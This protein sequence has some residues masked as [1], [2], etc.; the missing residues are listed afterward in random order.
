MKED[1]NRLRL[2]HHGD[3]EMMQ[4]ILQL[5]CRSKTASKLTETLKCQAFMFPSLAVAEMSTS[6][7]VAEIHASFIP[8]GADVLDMTFGL[9]IDSF[10][11]ARRARKVTAIEFNPETFKAGIHNI[12]ALGLENLTLEEGD[13]IRWLRDHGD[14]CFDVIFIDPARRDNAGRHYALKDCQPDIIPALPMLLSRCRRLII[15]ASPMLDIKKAIAELGVSCDVITT[16]TVKECKELVFLIDTDRIC[17]D[18]QAPSRL[19]TNCITVGRQAYSFTPEEEN[20]AAP[21]YSTPI[22]GGVLLEPF[23]SVMKGG[24]LK[25]LSERFGTG[26]LHPNTSLFCA[27]EQAEDFPGEYF[28]IIEVLPFNKQTVKNFAKAYPVVNVAVRNFPLGAPQ[29]AAKLKIKEGGDT[30]VFGTT[31]SSDQKLLIVTSMGQ[32]CQRRGC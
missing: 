32:V 4:K 6:D 19:S 1:F 11:F 9:G 30:M 28:R 16:G 22:A 25:L 8:D 13:S 29:L 10:H 23:P 31:A 20:N 17:Q 2:K 5:E 14:D 12:K 15:K 18:N 24:G 3:P 21:T 26:K 27:D 7:A